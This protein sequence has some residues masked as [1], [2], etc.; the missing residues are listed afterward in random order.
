MGNSLSIKKIN[1]EEL[2]A[3]VNDRNIIISTL[4]DD[5]QDCLIKHTISIQNESQKINDLLK[6]NKQ[7]LIVIYGKNSHDD[8]V[9]TKSKQL[10][11]LGFTNI[12]LYLG[13]LFEWLLLQDI[14]GEELFPTTSKELDLLKFK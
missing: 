12:N 1:F 6:T 4:P 3:S 7:G 11:Q 8:S 9:I 2:Q 14:Y 5:E 10:I 13:G